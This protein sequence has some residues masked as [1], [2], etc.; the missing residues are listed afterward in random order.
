M[1]KMRE[2][3][4]YFIVEFLLTISKYFPKQILYKIFE[5]FSIFIFYA[6][7]NRRKITIENLSSAFQDKNEKEIMKLA[8]QCF[9]NVSKTVTEIL[10][11]YNNRL[12]INE[13]VIN[14]EELEKLKKYL[15]KPIIFVTAHFGNW[16]LL[17]HFL[18]LNGYK[19]GVI[20]RKGNNILIEEHITTP[21]REKYGNKNIYKNKALIQIVKFLKS[22]K[23]IG[24]LI[25]QKAGNDGVLTKFF[26]KKCYTVPTV[27]FLNKKFDVYVIPV[28][29]IREN[30]KFR[31]II[32]E[33][34]ACKDCTDIEYTQKLNDILEEII[35][36]YPN[37]WFWMHN[38]WKM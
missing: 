10:L 17:A 35:K 13:L 19:L 32:K 30:E 26:N 12:D 18:A 31:L 37:Q 28:F 6:D 22:K 7:K 27:A 24:L 36:M 15:N 3:L 34:V 29:L 33:N 11:I 21:F 2:K 25:D 8:K 14:K 23:N 38:R 9:I 16:E 5:I 1:K 4:E 20:G